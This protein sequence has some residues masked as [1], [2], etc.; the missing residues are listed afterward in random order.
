MQL[1][2]IDRQVKSFH[3]FSYIYRMPLFAYESAKTKRRL[4]KSTVSGKWVTKDAVCLG[5]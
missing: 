3:S 1:I 5:Q 4:I 2:Q